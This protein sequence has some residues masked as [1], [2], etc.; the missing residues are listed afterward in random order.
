MELGHGVL[1]GGFFF[2]YLLLLTCVLVT[3]K[4][5]KVHCHCYFSRTGGLLFI[6]A[7]KKSSA[8]PAVSD[9]WKL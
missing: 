3:N 2:F 9:K 6:P 5:A 7:Q 1:S 4:A 8:G